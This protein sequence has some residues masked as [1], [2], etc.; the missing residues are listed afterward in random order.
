MSNNKNF[1]LLDKGYPVLDILKQNKVYIMKNFTFLFFFF[2]F[3]PL[4]NRVL[5]IFL[6]GEV[7]VVVSSYLGPDTLISIFSVSSGFHCVCERESV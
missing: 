6:I 3:W 4:I 1:R 5:R 2:F 7:R